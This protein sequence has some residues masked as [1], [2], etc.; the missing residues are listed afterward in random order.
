MVATIH[1]LFTERGR[2][3]RSHYVDDTC[4]GVIFGGEV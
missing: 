4:V 3:R 2:F 1:K